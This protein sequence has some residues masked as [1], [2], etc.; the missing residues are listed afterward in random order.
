MGWDHSW[1]G[2]ATARADCAAPPRVVGGVMIGS[3][4][5]PDL[6]DVPQISDAVAIALAFEDGGASRDSRPLSPA[7]EAEA[8]ATIAQAMAVLRRKRRGEAPSPSPGAIAS[9]VVSL[10]CYR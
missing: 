4:A 9:R 1:K 3:W 5:C 8:D 6:P 7:I 10:A 2:G